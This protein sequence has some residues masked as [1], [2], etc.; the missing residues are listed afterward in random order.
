MGGV[1]SGARAPGPAARGVQVVHE[2]GQAL[3][4]VICE[5]V[6]GKEMPSD[7][8]P[9]LRYILCRSAFRSLMPYVAEITIYVTVYLETYVAS[10]ES[11][12]L[13]EPTRQAFARSRSSVTTSI[14]CCSTD[15]PFFPERLPHGHASTSICFIH[16][17]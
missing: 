8:I 7:L 2:D 1:G 5:S 11:D 9:A 3:V 13:A 4:A 14:A 12:C 6:K 16:S 10:F 15:L 17:S